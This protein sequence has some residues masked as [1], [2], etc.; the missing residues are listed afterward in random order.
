MD[1]KPI[2]RLLR[3]MAIAGLGDN[4]TDLEIEWEG[5]RVET[6][7]GAAAMCHDLR[8]SDN[9]DRLFRA[10]FTGGTRARDDLGVTQIAAATPGASP[11]IVPRLA[12][13]LNSILLENHTHAHD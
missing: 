13:G 6:F 9:P 12:P 7:W 1:R 5:G 8:R 3:R 11:S 2:T 10:A 4:G